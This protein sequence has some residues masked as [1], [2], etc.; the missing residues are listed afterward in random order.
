MYRRE[1]LSER[2]N[3]MERGIRLFDLSKT[4]NLL[5]SFAADFTLYDKM[6]SGN[7]S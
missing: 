6:A 1:V 4:L 7:E 3:K 2:C 5:S